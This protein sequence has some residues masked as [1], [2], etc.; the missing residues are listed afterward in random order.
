MIDLLPCGCEIDPDNEIVHAWC[1]Y[2][3][4][5][6]IREVQDCG[7]CRGQ[8]TVEHGRCCPECNGA[9][10]HRMSGEEMEIAR[11]D[12]YWLDWREAG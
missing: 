12:A 7:S 10:Y 8:G 6:I 4:G 9:S 3:E 11:A 2:H 1:P 5:G